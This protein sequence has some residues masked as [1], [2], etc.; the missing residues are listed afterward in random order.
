VTS[1]PPRGT[2]VRAVLFDYGL[3]LI[4]FSRPVDALRVAYERIAAMLP[5]EW[6]AEHLLDLVH[7]R[8]DARVA[9]HES[10][11][12]LHE[13]DIHAAHREAYAELGAD[14]DDAT[15]DRAMQ[16]EQE[17]WWEGVHLAPD[18]AGTLAALRRDGLRVGVCSNAPYRPGSMR[19]QLVHV[20]LLPL[21][22]SATFSGEVGWRKPS[23]RIFAAALDALGADAATTVMVGDRVREDVEGAHAAG[24]RAVRLR[25]HHDDPAAG[26]VDEPADALL[27]RL[28]DLPSL[29]GSARI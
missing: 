1:R 19:D 27:D 22:D 11:G 23:P 21:I 17:A 24:M 3:T 4:T 10:A 25:E 13:L 6:D 28:A 18:V 14:L 16:I 15:L 12:E 20:G 2:P 7:D 26:G 29:L 8:V 5:G 9:A